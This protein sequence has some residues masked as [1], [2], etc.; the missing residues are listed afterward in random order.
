[1][2][3]TID[4]IALFT[5]IATSSTL[6]GELVLALKREAEALD[7]NGVVSARLLNTKAQFLAAFDRVRDQLRDH[8]DALTEPVT[9]I[10][11]K[12]LQQQVAELET[13]A[14]DTLIENHPEIVRFRFERAGIRLHQGCSEA[15]QQ[16]YLAVLTQEPGHFG[17]LND[18]AIIAAEQG[19]LK[20]ARDLFIQAVTMHP[21]Q[22]VGHVNFADFLLSQAEYKTAQSHYRT[23]L[24]LNPDLNEAHQGLAQ[25]LTGLGDEAGAARHRD[26]AFVGRR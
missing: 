16:D 9:E 17:A 6:A 13:A 18:L 3:H 22:A 12:K 23:A 24:E 4:R 19:R 5:A 2:T 11:F 10:V 15:A 1:M 21:G 26:R 14:L 25:A 8:A 7:G 20:E